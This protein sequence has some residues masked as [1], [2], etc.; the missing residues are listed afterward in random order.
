MK[1]K[2]FFLIPLLLIFF[3]CSSDNNDVTAEKENLKAVSHEVL[4]FEYI[5]ET[6]NNSHRLR[7][8]I[9]YTNPNNVA[10][11][12]FSNITMDYDG[13]ILTPIKKLPPYIEIDANSSFTESFDV[14]EAFDINIGKVNSIKLVSIK[15]TIVKN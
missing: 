10:I 3:G 2:V 8:N 7:Y 9:K 4:L 13:L 12:G 11:K 1:T 15:F 6:G 5:P 14:E